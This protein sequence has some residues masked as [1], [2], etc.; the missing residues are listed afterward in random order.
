MSALPQNVPVRTA[1]AARS[2]DARPSGAARP[3]HIPAPRPPS[4][5]AARAGAAPEIR[6][7]SPRVPSDVARPAGH[8][9]HPEAGKHR[10]VV[11]VRSRGETALL[12]AGRVGSLTTLAALLVVSAAFAGM[13]DGSEPTGPA[14][15]VATTTLR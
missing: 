15:Q 4:D 8:G 11:P 13:L 12:L 6:I 1:T 7:P 10:A 14:A 5:R 2:G 9:A 3:L